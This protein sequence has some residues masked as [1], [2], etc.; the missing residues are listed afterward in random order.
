MSLSMEAS[1]ATSGEEEEVGRGKRS[2]HEW[3]MGHKH[4]SI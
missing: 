2:V 3:P 1:E 4:G